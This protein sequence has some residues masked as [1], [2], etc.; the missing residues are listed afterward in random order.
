[1]FGLFSE[2]VVRGEGCREGVGWRQ[3]GDDEGGSKE[4]GNVWKGLRFTGGVSNG[5]GGGG[6]D[7]TVERKERNNGYKGKGRE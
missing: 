1:M 6:S 2:G 5:G 4:K 3:G 7:V